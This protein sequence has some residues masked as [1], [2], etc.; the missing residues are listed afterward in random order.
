MFR[1]SQNQIPTETKSEQTP[2][3]VFV[4]VENYKTLFRFAPSEYERFILIPVHKIF[5]RFDCY[6]RDQTH[7]YCCGIAKSFVSEQN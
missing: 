1:F 7:R 6:F 4:A 3:A 5:E 2:R